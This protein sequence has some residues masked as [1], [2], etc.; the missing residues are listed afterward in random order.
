[1]TAAPDPLWR[2]ML[3]RSDDALQ[4][5]G[6]AATDDGAITAAHLLAVA[7]WLRRNFGYIAPVRD[8]IILA[9][10]REARAAKEAR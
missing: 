4:D 10:Q 6:S 2:Q 1:M 5:P 8:G 7:D 9:L 3:N